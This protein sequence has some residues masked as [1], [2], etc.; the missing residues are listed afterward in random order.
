MI[1]AL[2]LLAA[3]TLYAHGQSEWPTFNGDFSGK[4]FSSLKQV[5]RSNVASL[6]LAWAFQTDLNSGIGLKSTPLLI[7]GTLFFTAPDDV[8][9]VDARTGQ[10]NWHYHYRQNEGLHIGQRG[11]GYHSNKLYFETPDAHLQCLDA[12]TGKVKW[13]VVLADVKLGFWATMAPLVIRDH[14]LAGISGDFNDLHGFIDSFDPETG[15]LQWQWNSLP[16]PG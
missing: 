13:D 9:S 14:V 1:R 5:D 12:I 16:K 8:W 10:Q 4:R 3:T 6:A 2:A 15:K 11:L 7:N